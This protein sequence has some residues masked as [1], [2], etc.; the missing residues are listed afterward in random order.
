MGE[1]TARFALSGLAAAALLLGGCASIGDAPARRTIAIAGSRVFPESITADAAGNLYNGSVPGII[2]RTLAGADT[3]Q[4]FI[5][6]DPAN[7]LRA[8]FGV[9]ADDARALLWVCDNPNLFA[10]VTGTSVLRA[11]RLAD[12]ALT[13]SHPFPQGPAA[14]NDIAIAPDG[15]VWVSETS[16]G[17]IFTL[18]PGAQ[19]LALFAAGPELVGIDGLAFAGDGT[20]YINNVRQQ[21]F[22]RV[23]RAADGRF[24]GLTALA[25]SL[26]LAGPDGLRPLGGNRFIQGEGGNG[27]VALLE[28]AGD[29]LAV[30]PLAEGLNG[31]VGVAVTGGI[32]FVV[33]G[34]I[35]YLVDPAL[36]GQSPD[37]FTIRAFRLPEAE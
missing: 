11:F 7:G 5:V 37:P 13:S 16:G 28:V 30:T 23:E 2:Y 3:A 25:P 29:T 24:A 33:E 17:R 8:V 34:K 14:C 20:L 4:P 36:R 9:L 18:A 6:P 10:G 31:P 1:W 32:A 12:G 35:G 19:D 27:R 22:Q 15:T 21:L 26:P